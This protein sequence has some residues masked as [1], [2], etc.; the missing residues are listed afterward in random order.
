V[1][2]DD[3]ARRFLHAVARLGR[4]L[5]LQLVAEGVERPSQL[6][7]VRELGDVLV[8]GYLFGAARPA[9][10]LDANPQCLVGTGVAPA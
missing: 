6:A 7:V 2:A 3:E 9:D 8:Q 10:Q 1:D 5:G 4:D